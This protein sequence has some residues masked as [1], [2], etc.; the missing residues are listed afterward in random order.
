MRSYYNINKSVPI[1]EM[2]SLSAQLLTKVCLLTISTRPF[3]ALA[4][5]TTNKLDDIQR[6]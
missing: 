1:P 3:D 2:V 4:H 5:L 6:L